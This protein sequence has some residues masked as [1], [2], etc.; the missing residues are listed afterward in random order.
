MQNQQVLIILS[1]GFPANENDT[2]CLPAQQSLVRCINK[3][4][5]FL[6]II[7]LS[8]QYPYTNQ[9]YEWYGNRVVPFNGQNRKRLF[10]WLLWRRVWKKLNTIHE[11]HEPVGI[12]SFWLD[13]CALL[14][15]RFAK[16]KSMLHFT[17]LLGQDAREGN[18]YV[19]M[20]RPSASSLIA[21]SDRLSKTFF[22][23]YG[24][25]PSHI[26]TNGIDTSLYKK[27]IPIKTIDILG[28]GSLIALKQ[29]DLFIET[30]ALI[31][32]QY[33][34]VTAMICGKGPEKEKL[35]KLIEEKGLIKNI[36]LTGELSHEE[37]L[38]KMQCSKILLH[39]SS[40]EGFSGVCLEALYA[41]A[42]VISFFNAQDAWI[43]HWHIVNDIH[44]MAE[45]A[46]LL[47]NDPATEYAPVLPYE[48]KDTAK[49]M[50]RL[51]G[52]QPIA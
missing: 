40:Y 22:N 37:V 34:A 25:R 38:K 21:I 4:F 1:P 28:V 51:F 18:R 13:E 23:N 19:K 9:E 6:K 14:G 30:V 16:K 39:N 7:I 31:Q 52:I 44:A 36:H 2:A 26:I 10:R 33:P 41:G 50:M 8:F 5:P 49:Q 24:I 12:L 48:M 43:R 11:E 42:H 35:E 29:F 20:I 15:D 46:L 47:L 3:E 45:K 17:W 27:D 32:K